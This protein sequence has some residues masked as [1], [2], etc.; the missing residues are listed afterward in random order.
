MRPPPNVR[1][2]RADDA[3]GVLVITKRSELEAAA[4]ST[5]LLLTSTCQRSVSFRL[6]SQ[7]VGR[8]PGGGARVAAV[9]CHPRLG[10]RP[11]CVLRRQ[12]ASPASPASLHCSVMSPQIC[13]NRA[14]FSEPCILGIDEAGRGPVLGPMVYG[15]GAL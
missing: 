15:A 3:G 9:L 1:R 14:W 4:S 12:C 10:S 11:A 6:R 5:R 7:S 8:R 2:R 13:S